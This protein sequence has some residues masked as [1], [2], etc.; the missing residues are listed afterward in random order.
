MRSLS[1]SPLSSLCFSS[2]LPVF[3]VRILSLDNSLV[4][5]QVALQLLLVPYWDYARFKGVGAFLCRCAAASHC[6]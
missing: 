4:S 6:Q 3:R 1:V 5:W 2:L